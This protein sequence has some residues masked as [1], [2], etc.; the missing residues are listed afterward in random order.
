M[1]Q[2]RT[3]ATAAFLGPAILL[4]GL[5]WHP[6]IAKL[7]D[8]DAV[9]HALAQDATRWF[10]SHFVVAI[11]AAVLLLAFLGVR[12]HIRATVGHEPWTSRA[13]VPL[14]LGTVLFALLPGMEIGILAVHESGGDALAAQNQLD[15]WFVP[16]L[17]AGSLLF[18][19]G[20]VL[21]A[22][23]VRKAAILPSTT[24]WLVVSALMV[25]AASRFVPM[26]GSLLVGALA[27]VIA[28]WTL[29]VTMWQAGGA[30]T[31]MKGSP[32]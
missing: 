23:G 9:V 3:A 8:N 1:N 28:F 7:T 21:F 32:A 4:A 27:L 14:V 2:D 16:V 13:I 30:S 24:S 19:A 25:S 22:I 10:L 31:A 29:G 12:A 20:S 26:T 18:A 5:L 11:G 6:F 15:T 17:L